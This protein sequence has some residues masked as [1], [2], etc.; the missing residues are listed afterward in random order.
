M[1]RDPKS[2]HY[3]AGGIEVQ[4]IIIAKLTPE[5][6]KGWC[7]GNMIKYPA[8]L[9]FKNPD[10]PLRDAEK[11]EHYSGFLTSH[12]KSRADIECLSCYGVGFYVR[13]PGEQNLCHVCNGTGKKPGGCID[14]P[15]CSGT[16]F[17][18][19]KRDGV[20]RREACPD[21]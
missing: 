12:L 18:N 10:D 6:Y 4:D 13:S 9:N 3:D 8:R 20:K 5:Q 11:S 14:C 17:I 1:S 16:Q 19:T 2:S 15:T 7:L 21:C